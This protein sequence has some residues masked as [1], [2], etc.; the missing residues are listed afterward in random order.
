MGFAVSCY[1]V[2]RGEPTDFQNLA[3]RVSVAFLWLAAPAAATAQN[4]PVMVGQD[5]EAAVAALKAGGIATQ[6]T[7]SG[8]GRTVTY[9]GGGESVKLQF[10]MWPKDPG[11]PASAW[12]AGS[13]AEKKLVLTRIEDVAPSSEPR[14]AWVNSLTREGNGWAYLSPK[15]DAS[16]PAGDRAKYPVAASLQWRNPPATL[17]FQ[18]ARAAGTP[19]GSEMT[20]LEITLENPH[21]PRRF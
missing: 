14:R 11:A 16:R 3:L 6:E 20:A 19:P 13:A 2:R 9:T 8:T 7:S 17:L 5:Y 4:L 18:A 10:A 12:E 15:A 21:K 1:I